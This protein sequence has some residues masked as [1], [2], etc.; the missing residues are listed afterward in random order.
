MISIRV[1]I[2]FVA[3]ISFVITSWFLPEHF[4]EQ[5]RIE[6]RTIYK[7]TSQMAIANAERDLKNT[8]EQLESERIN[9]AIERAKQNEKFTAY[10]NDVRIG[11]IAGLRI[12]KPSVCAT[13]FEKAA[14]TRGVVEEETIRLP[15]TI[16]E[17]LFRFA[18][19][20]DKIIMDFEAFKQDVRIAKCFS[21]Y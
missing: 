19:D 10:V 1:I 7:V 17:G 6:Q 16:E 9:N 18:H 12:N 13:G 8:E 2:G 15:R 4:R 5:G 3:L 20:R 21:E 14:S 11:R